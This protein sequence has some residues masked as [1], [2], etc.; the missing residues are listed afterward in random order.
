[1]Y[2]CY[3]CAKIIKGPAVMT[4]PPVV[5][6][7]LGLDFVKAFHP[8]CHERSQSEAAHALGRESTQPQ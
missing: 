8:K 4:N 5:N 6:I 1:M 2:T 3:R 7:R